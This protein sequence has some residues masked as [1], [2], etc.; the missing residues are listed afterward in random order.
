[1]DGTLPVIVAR[2]DLRDV[3]KQLGNLGD[4][5]FKNIQEFL[6]KILNHQARTVLLGS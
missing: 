3:Y 4:S 6:S 2:F 5:V 1:M